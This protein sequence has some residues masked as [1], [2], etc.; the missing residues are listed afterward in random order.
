MEIGEDL[1]LPNSDHLPSHP[2]QSLKILSITFSIGA[3]LLPPEY[4]QL[5]FPG[6]QSIAM[7]KITIDKNGYLLV[8]E[9]RIGTAR[10]SLHVFSESI[11][12]FM[13][14]RSDRNFKTSVFQLHVGHR[15]ETLV[16]SAGI[17]HF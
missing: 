4:I 7:P 8:R 16:R 6:W 13:Q 12:P 10:Q 11:A 14:F 15:A 17:T 5:V 9:N 1:M 2:S 3:Y